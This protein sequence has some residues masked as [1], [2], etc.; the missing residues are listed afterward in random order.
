MVNWTE[1]APDGY[2][3]PRHDGGPVV[4]TLAAVVVLIG[5]LLWLWL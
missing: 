5:L 3:E 1:E 4:W 2:D